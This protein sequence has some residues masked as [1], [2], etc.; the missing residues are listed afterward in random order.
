MVKMDPRIKTPA[1]ALQQQ[2]S[3]SQKLA[4]AM[5]QTFDALEALRA[6]RKARPDD[7]ALAELEGEAEPRRPWEKREQKPTLAAW[8]AR[9]SGAYQL[10]QSTDEAP[11]PQAVSEA[12]KVLKESAE[13]LQ[14]W[15]KLKH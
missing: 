8:H 5:T 13:L 3:L 12:E 2:F 7:K 1:A 4:L 15:E 14:R 9:L 10:L 6:A 11:L